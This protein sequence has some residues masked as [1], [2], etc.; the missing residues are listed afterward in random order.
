MV[1]SLSGLARFRLGFEVRLNTSCMGEVSSRSGGE[2]G[3]V[4]FAGQEAACKS[5]K[6]INGGCRR[7]TNQINAMIHD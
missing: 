3:Y 4:S 7:G 2:G 1:V 6:S 5:E